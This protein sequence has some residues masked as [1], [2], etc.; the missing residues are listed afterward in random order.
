ML[1]RMLFPRDG[2]SVIGHR[3]MKLPGPVAEQTAV[4]FIEMLDLP[5]GACLLDTTGGAWAARVAGRWAC[6]VAHAGT[7]TPAD[8]LPTA[9]PHDAR[10]YLWCDLFGFVPDRSYDLVLCTRAPLSDGTMPDHLVAARELLKPGGQLLLGAGYWRL[11]PS[12]AFLRKSGLRS[13][14]MFGLGATLASAEE[15][16]FRVKHWVSSPPK[17]WDGYEERFRENLLQWADRNAAHP[18]SPAVRAHAEEWFKTY[19]VEG[20]YVVGFALLLLEAE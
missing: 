16:G 19:K 15:H 11:P 17:E 10:H 9:A 14:E 13:G 18:E 3:G 4:E 8:G 2:Y 6:G 12:A 1:P 20:K 7:H 5:R